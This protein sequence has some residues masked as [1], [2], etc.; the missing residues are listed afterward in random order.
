MRLEEY[1]ALPFESV[2]DYIVE[3]MKNAEIAKRI[4]EWK[5][6]PRFEIKID[7]IVFESVAGRLN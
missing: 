1:G 6:D 7:E 2:K 3:S 5:S 4:D